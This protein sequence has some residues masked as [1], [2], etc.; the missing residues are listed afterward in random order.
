MSA[1]YRIRTAR[2]DEL[3]RL[4][5]IELA[6]AALFK[7]VG[8]PGEMTPDDALSVD[9][10]RRYHAAGRLWLAVDAAD[11]PVA[12]AAAS[13]VDGEA[14]LDELDVHPDHGRQGIGRALIEQVCD[15]AR[16]AGFDTLTL[17]TE[18]DVPWN[19]PYYA[20]LGFAIIPPDALGAGLR[21]ILANEVATL[22]DIATRVAMRRSL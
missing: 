6:A 22:P 21:A 10:H 17:T 12:F 15:W 9:D 11:Q 3:D 2:A 19:A 8:W 14:H 20:R 18:R 7:S 5:A 16:G 4:P 13:V 1:E